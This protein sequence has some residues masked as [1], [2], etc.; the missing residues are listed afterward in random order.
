MIPPI[1]MNK[2]SHGKRNKGGDGVITVSCPLGDVT[3]G[4]QLQKH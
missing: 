4:M 1:E 2:A 3:P